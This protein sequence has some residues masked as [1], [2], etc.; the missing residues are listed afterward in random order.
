MHAM[1][2]IDAN[3]GGG[4]NQ[5]GDNDHMGIKRTIVSVTINYYVINY[6]VILGL[7]KRR[8][9]LA[10]YICQAGNGERLAPVHLVDVEP[11]R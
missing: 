3:G 10:K 1:V 7:S 2:P 4:A 8:P 9:G 6:I 11:A 5:E